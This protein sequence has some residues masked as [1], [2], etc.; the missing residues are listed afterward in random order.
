MAKGHEER[1]WDVQGI[2]G[3]KKAAGRDCEQASEPGLKRDF[4]LEIKKIS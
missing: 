2:T 4:E 1:S 3:S